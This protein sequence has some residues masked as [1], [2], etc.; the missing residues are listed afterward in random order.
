MDERRLT[1]LFL[2][3]SAYGPTSNCVGIG[4]VLRERGHR[5]V[6]A[7]ERSWAGHLTARGFEEVVVDIESA[8]EGSGPEPDPFWR[9]YVDTLAPEFRRSTYEQLETVIARMWAT[10]IQGVKRAEPQLRRAV[11]ELRPDIV[12]EDNVVLFPALATAGVPLV[13]IASCNPLEVP[14]TD[15]PPIFSGYPS[16]DRSQWSRFRAEFERTHRRLWEDFDAWA[17]RQGAAPLPYLRFMPEADVNL[18]LYP[19]VADYVDRREMNPNWI[20]LESSVRRA[21]EPFEVPE[22]IAHGEGSLIYFSLGTLGAG[23]VRLMQRLIDMLEHTVHRYIVALGPRHAELRLPRNVWGAE[24]VPQ[25]SILPLV[26][27]VITHGGNNTVTEAFHFGKPMVVMPL[28]WDQYDN[29]QRV[30]ELGFGAR[31]DPHRVTFREL[32]E[33]VERLLGNAWMRQ[34]LREIGAEIRER[35]GLGRAAD[36]IERAGIAHVTGTRV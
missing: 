36:E 20:R 8:P 27:L 19:E 11:A 5:V 22:K 26:D 29:A 28:F 6:F 25:T 31:L 4:D 15:V 10:L 16:N 3:E 9:G 7:S 32:H 14:G 1:V 21:D 18:Y 23:D 30:Q 33:A 13:R 35:D 12:V 17:Q 34:R 24:F 2:P